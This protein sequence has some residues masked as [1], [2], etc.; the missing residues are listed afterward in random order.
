MPVPHR[1]RPSWVR[2]ACCETLSPQCFQLL[3]SLWGWD[4]P[5]L[6]V[7]YSSHWEALRWGTDKTAA[8]AK[9]VVLVTHVAPLP[10]ISRSVGNKNSSERWSVVVQFRTTATSASRIQAILLPQPPEYLG[11]QV[12]APMS[13]N[14][15]I[16]IRDGVPSYWPGWSQTPDLLICPSWPHKSLTQLPR[17]ECSGVILVHCNLCLLGSS[18]SPASASP[19]A[20]ITGRCQHAQ[21]IFVFLVDMEFHHVGQACLELLTSDDTPPLASQSA[22]TTTESSFVA[23]LECSGAIS[24]HCNL[25]LA[26]SSNSPASASRVAGTTGTHYH[27]QLIFIFFSR[28]GVSPCW[29]GWSR[30]LDLVI[31]P[32]R[33]PKV[34]GL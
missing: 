24:A 18:N 27:A 6:T 13:A 34:L 2:C 14:F 17:L 1:A 26:G 28:D 20:G 8:P 15:C 23:R 7:P 16:F 5:S 3:F 30:S 12:H 29:P 22:R 25:C 19:V 33:P 21:P 32:P 4:Q 10:G 11:L 9:R 31:C